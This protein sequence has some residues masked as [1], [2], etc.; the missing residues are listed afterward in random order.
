MSGSAIA[1]KIKALSSKLVVIN[2]T[3]LSELLTCKIITWQNMQKFK[4][5]GLRRN[6]LKPNMPCL[7][8]YIV[9]CKLTKFSWT[10]T[11]E[12]AMAIYHKLTY[13]CHVKNCSYYHHFHF[14]EKV[15]AFACSVLYEMLFLTITMIV[16]YSTGGRVDFSKLLIL[17]HRNL[18]ETCSAS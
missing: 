5:N 2:N 4:G 9:E 10:Q 1:P 6:N 8:G 12:N 16:K 13:Y 15:L 18:C 17:V 7:F 11:C 3:S 14:L